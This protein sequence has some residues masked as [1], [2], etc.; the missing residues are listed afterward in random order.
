VRKFD[1][2]RARRDKTRTKPT[3]N[4]TKTINTT[5]SLAQKAMMI[6]ASELCEH[7]ADTDKAPDEL[8]VWVNKPASIMCF[9]CLPD[10]C[11]TCDACGNDRLNNHLAVQARFMDGYCPD[12]QSH[13]PHDTPS[14]IIHVMVCQQCYG[15]P[16]NQHH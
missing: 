6:G 14:L 8:F 10:T 5:V 3:D 13:A 12:H 4:V 2:V 9:R 1:K 7:L 16:D 15:K 11:D